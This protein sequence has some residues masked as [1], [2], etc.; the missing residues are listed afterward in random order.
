MD[1]TIRAQND[2]YIDLSID[3]VKRS[4]CFMS[5]IP[6]IQLTA[7]M[8]LCDKYQYTFILPIT[9]EQITPDKPFTLEQIEELD[10]VDALSVILEA[11]NIIISE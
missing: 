1:L 10:T 3:T 4:V 11:A 7:L 2:N 8:E 9:G 6:D 5:P